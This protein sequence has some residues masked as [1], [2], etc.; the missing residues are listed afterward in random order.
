MR[1]IKLREIRNGESQGGEWLGKI[2]KE[3]F[4]EKGIV[5]LG[6][7]GDE[8]ISYGDILRGKLFRQ[9]EERF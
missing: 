7:E 3:G 2:I 4:L 6:F 9:M 5:V 1:K 8:R